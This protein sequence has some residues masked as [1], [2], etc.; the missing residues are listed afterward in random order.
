[1]YVYKIKMGELLQE[2]KYPIV[3][4]NQ[5]VKWLN[6]GEIHVKHKQQEYKHLAAIQKCFTVELLGLV[7]A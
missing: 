2:L 6:V 4:L 7:T 3:L 5:L 1:M